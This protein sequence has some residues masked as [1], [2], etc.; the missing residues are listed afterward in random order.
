MNRPIHPLCAMSPDMSDD[1]YREFKADIET[2]GQREA[3]KLWNGSIID[4]RHRDR[5]CREL[6]REPITASIEI[7]EDALPA[8]VLSLNAMRSHLSV[9]QRAMYAANLTAHLKRGWNL[10]QHADVQIRT[11]TEGAADAVGVSRGMVW[12]A[13]RIQQSAAPE[14]VAAVRRGALTLHAADQ[15]TDNIPLEEQP[16]KVAEVTA[17]PIPRGR[18]VVPLTGGGL[19]K[20]PRSREPVE[21]LVDRAV[22]SIDVSTQALA[23]YGERS[24]PTAEQRKQWDDILERAAA[25]IRRFR[26]YIKVEAA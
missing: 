4:G 23:E 7:D 22:T 18:S 16:A 13:K 19:P 1:Q 14:V 6:G 24:N 25:V 11:S 10:N 15:I 5:A 26:A 20:P 3:V 12:K 8:Y 2:N 9:S 21:N 17:K